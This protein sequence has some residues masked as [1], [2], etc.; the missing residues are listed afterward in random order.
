VLTSGLRF[1][2]AGLH[3]L[4]QAAALIANAA[5]FRRIRLLLSGA[6]LVQT[7]TGCMLTSEH[8]DLALDIPPA[9]Q[10]AR[11]A[12]YAAPPAL[13]WWRG[14]R[15]AELTSLIEEA[16]TA[17]LDIAAA[18]AR[19]RPPGSPARR[20]SRCSPSTAATHGRGRRERPARTSSP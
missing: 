15:S 9:Y 8:L 20:C 3:R 13:D 1:Q 2:S 19:M 18:M 12:P 10:E 16:Q 17:N 5:H 11:G 4:A 14:F 7:L 6:M